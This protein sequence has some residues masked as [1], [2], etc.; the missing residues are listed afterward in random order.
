MTTNNGDTKKLNLSVSQEV[1]DEFNAFVRAKH[2]KT[3]EMTRARVGASNEAAYA[4]L[5]IGQGV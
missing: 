3:R 5:R 2:G 4:D 1:Y